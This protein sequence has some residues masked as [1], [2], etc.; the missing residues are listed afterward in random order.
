M[1]GGD[2]TGCTCQVVSFDIIERHNCPFG[3]QNYGIAYFRRT[4][5]PKVAHPGIKA[6]H[7]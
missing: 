7:P 6:E 4:T 1:C 2:E 5:D 3:M